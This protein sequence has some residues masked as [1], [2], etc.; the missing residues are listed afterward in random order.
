[1]NRIE[2]WTVAILLCIAVAVYDM[3]TGWTV[4]G[5]LAALVVVFGLFFG[6]FA[7]YAAMLR[8]LLKERKRML[9]GSPDAGTVLKRAAGAMRW[10][11]AFAIGFSVL[12]FANCSGGVGPPNSHVSSAMV[13]PADFIFL[14]TW[15]MAPLLVALLLPPLLA[16]GAQVLAG[17]SP[18]TAGR[19]AQLVVWGCALAAGAAVITVPIGFFLGVSSCDVG[20]SAGYCAAGLGSLLNFFSLGS[21]ALFLP[22][23][24]LLTWALARMEYDRANPK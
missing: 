8:A 4:S 19:L 24:G 20:P 14:T 22:Y 3:L 18:K 15:L 5:G 17:T 1:M 11:G 6:A 16:T 9:A 23:T 13:A 7:M 2:T 21:L 12:L 10:A